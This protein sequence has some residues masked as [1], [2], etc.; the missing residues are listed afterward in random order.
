MTEHVF[1]DLDHTLWDFE[2]N[3]ETCLKEIYAG[4]ITGRVPYENFVSTFRV[5]NKGLWRQLETGTI[6]HD[7]LRR[8]RF[9][10]TLLT[11]DVPCPEEE[12]L[13][14]NEQFMELLPQQKHLM[15]GAMEVLEYLRPKYR[16]HIISNGYLDIQTR[17]MTG[18]GIFPYFSRI[19][20]SDVSGARKPDS[21]IFE[22]ALKSAG[23]TAE[24]SI[25][26]GDDEIADKTGS[27]NAGLPYIHFDPTASASTPE[28][29]RELTELKNFL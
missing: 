21:K 7:E 17:K 10:N 29:I 14:M 26:I 28:V 1:F 9:K 20:T 19:I 15:E 8:T 22:Y 5:I 18:S 23:T 24:R 25:Y 16:L 2:R 12:S 11:L 27:E 4:R 6:T 13:A 3:S